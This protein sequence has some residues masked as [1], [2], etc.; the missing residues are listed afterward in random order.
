M[1]ISQ[2]TDKLEFNRLESIDI[3]AS[4][5]YLRSRLEAPKVISKPINHQ[6]YRFEYHFSPKYLLMTAYDQ[7]RLACYSVTA[8]N[9]T[10]NPP[11]PHHQNYLQDK[12]STF[13]EHNILAYRFSSDT[14]NY[15]LFDLGSSVSS[16]HQ[17][18]IVGRVDYTTS[19][20]F[21]SLMAKIEGS[22]VI[23]DNI[24]FEQAVNRLRLKY[25][26][27]FYAVCEWPFETVVESI[28]SSYQ[29]S[30]FR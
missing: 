17:K 21:K 20:Q 13:M 7:Q 23:D 15:V 10:F 22:E 24:E 19:S 16:Q 28:L 11:I 5:E 4:K 27:N 14:A 9:D 3:G 6:N 8:L 1:V 30:Q 18:L 26:A 2:F 12:I 29:F 25:T